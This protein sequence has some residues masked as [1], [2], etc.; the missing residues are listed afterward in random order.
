MFHGW[1]EINLESDMYAY[2][3][4]TVIISKNVC[5]GIKNDLI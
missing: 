3:Q 1:L 5:M 2:L 4:G